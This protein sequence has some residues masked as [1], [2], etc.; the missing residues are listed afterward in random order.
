M[1]KKNTSN[2]NFIFKQDHSFETRKNESSRILDKYSDRI[3]IIVERSNKSDILPLIDKKK[4]LCPKDLTI[5]QF[6]YVIRKRI[7]LNPNKAIFIFINNTL[8]PISSSVGDI[9]GQ[10]MDEDGFLYIMY[11]S[12][13]T[14]G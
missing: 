6:V 10:H 4:F 7:S 5:G 1:K 9:Y 3:P 2:M 14:F 12:E 8:P 13:N 11:S